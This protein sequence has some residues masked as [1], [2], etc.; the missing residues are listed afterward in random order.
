MRLYRK[1]KYHLL[2]PS[3]CVVLIQTS[4]CMYF[5]ANKLHLSMPSV[6]SLTFF[7]TDVNNKPGAEVQRQSMGYNTCTVCA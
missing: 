2:Y 5:P 6:I 3:H 1:V 7:W 4:S